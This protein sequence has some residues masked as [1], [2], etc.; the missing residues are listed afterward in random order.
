MR[1]KAEA[2]RRS[3]TLRYPYPDGTVCRH[4][5]GES[6]L[7]AEGARKS[8]PY[9]SGKRTEAVKSADSVFVRLFWPVSGDM[10]ETGFFCYHFSFYSLPYHGIEKGRES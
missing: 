8:F 1:E 9:L 3:K 10:M 7:G 6:L 2:Y 5:S 4:D